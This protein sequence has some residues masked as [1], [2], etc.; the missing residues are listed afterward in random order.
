MAIDPRVLIPRL[1]DL[2]REAGHWTL[3]SSNT[4]A[5]ADHHFRLILEEI[6]RFRQLANIAQTQ[7]EDDHR[8][9][10]DDQRRVDG[11]V[12]EPGESGECERLL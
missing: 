11:V 9:A 12:S 7:A 6:S 2:I 4:I 5:D 1:A 3:I 8:G 10:L